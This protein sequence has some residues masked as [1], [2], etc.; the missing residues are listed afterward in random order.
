MWL[1]GRYFGGTVLI[2]IRE[3]LNIV[4]T[5]IV[6]HTALAH[7]DDLRSAAKHSK[8]A[9]KCAFAC[10]DGLCEDMD[11]DGSEA[12]VTDEFK[13]IFR[14]HLQ[15]VQHRTVTDISEHQLDELLKLMDTGGT[16]HRENAES[17]EQFIA[18]RAIAVKASLLTVVNE[19]S[20]D[21]LSKFASETL[22]KDY[23]SVR[24]MDISGNS[25]RDC[26]ARWTREALASE[27]QCQTRSAEPRQGE[28]LK[29]EARLTSRPE[30]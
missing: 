10:S 26:S 21:E 13:V 2:S 11:V 14:A 7:G 17:V 6:D 9:W 18:R 16:G 19:L 3:F 28:N 15:L 30:R 22:A 23:R 27:S 25:L 12:C 1:A 29:D 4:I 8:D 20:I 5:A 24:K